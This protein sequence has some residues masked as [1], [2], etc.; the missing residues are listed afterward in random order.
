MA[1]KALIPFLVAMML[2]TGV[3]NTLLTKYQV[4]CLA[5]VE[6][7]LTNA[8]SRTTN[9]FEI[10]TTLILSNGNILPV[11]FIKHYR[12]SSAKL[13]VGWLSEHIRYTAASVSAVLTQRLRDI[14]PSVP[15]TAKMVQHK[16]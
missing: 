6:D 3:C 13:A 5:S 7:K 9:V 16:R 8:S 15:R 1:F 10:A 4:C 12:C 14:K 11:L 2:V